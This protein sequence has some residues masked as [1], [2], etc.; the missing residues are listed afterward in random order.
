M[1][2]MGGRSPRKTNPQAARTAGKGPFRALT[3]LRRGATGPEVEALQKKLEECGFS[4]GKIDGQF[5]SGT[6]AAV[7]AFQKSQGLLPDGVAGPRTLSAL[8]LVKDDD[9][10]SAVPALTVQVVSEMCPAAPLGNIKANLPPVSEALA[11]ER[12]VD[13]PMLLMAIATV[14]AETGIFK[15]IG[16]YISRYNTSPN[17]GHSFDLYDHRR[18]LGNQGPPDGEQFKGRGFVQLTG[19]A[20]YT[21]YS[22]KLGLGDRLVREPESANDPQIAAK[23]LARF[24]KDRERAIKEAL[25]ENDLR[26]ARRLVNGG[27]HGLAEFTSAY[28]TGLRLIPEA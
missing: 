2:A 4:P 28:E 26:Q 13:K 1:T 18:D 6:E 8:G 7:I 21:L 22:K 15:P 11:A 23:L 3:I 20:N 14:R 9:L 24:L 5:G 27:T 10:P 16:E 17:A 12:L 19:R 25:I